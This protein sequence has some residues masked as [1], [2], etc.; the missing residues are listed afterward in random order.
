MGRTRY[1]FRASYDQYIPKLSGGVGLQYVSNRYLNG[2]LKEK[3]INGMYAYNISV[4]ENMH[5]RPAINIGLGLRQ[6][7]WG[8]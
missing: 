2:Y 4:N 8:Q 1:N 3:R 5:I 7:D 6:V